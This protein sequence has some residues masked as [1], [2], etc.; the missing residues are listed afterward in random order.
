[1]KYLQQQE[2]FIR[3]FGTITLTDDSPEKLDYL[4]KPLLRLA[5]HHVRGL[6][7]NHDSII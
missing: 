4:G 7:R 5:G 2:M 6:T 3:E 1:M